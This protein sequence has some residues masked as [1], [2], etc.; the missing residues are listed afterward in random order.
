MF[1]KMC[2]NKSGKLRKS[3]LT[4]RLMRGESQVVIVSPHLQVE[5]SVV[6]IKGLSQERLL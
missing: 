4:S 2:E 1:E 3:A 6:E 5:S